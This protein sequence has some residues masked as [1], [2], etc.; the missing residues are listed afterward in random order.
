MYGIPCI[1]SATILLK[2]CSMLFFDW[3]SACLPRWLSGERVRLMTWTGGYEFE[4][5]EAKFLSGLFSPL[6]SAEACE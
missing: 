2:V 1:T 4:T 5:V 3:A 6:T